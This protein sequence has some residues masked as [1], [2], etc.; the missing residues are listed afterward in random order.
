MTIKDALLYISP[1]P[2]GEMTAGFAAGMAQHFGAE[3]TG[4]TFAFDMAYPASLYTRLP[5]ELFQKLGEKS[6]EDAMVAMTHATRIF[7]QGT[8]KFI[9]VMETCLPDEAIDSFVE[10]ARLRDIAILP[11]R[12]EKLPIERS[13]IEALLFGSGL[14]VMLIPSR[15]ENDLCD[16]SDFD[17]LGLQPGGCACRR[18][19]HAAADECEAGPH[20][21]RDRR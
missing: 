19:R 10:Y 16:R 8:S 9:G 21:Y 5:D 20:R 4:L 6:R 11:N 14:P 3:V 2:G 12:R 13:L 15:R 18:R 7:D 17:R 1:A